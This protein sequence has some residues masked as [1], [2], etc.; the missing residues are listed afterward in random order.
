MYELAQAEQ[1]STEEVF[2][3]GEITV[4]LD[5]SVINNLDS[6][7]VIDYKNN[8]GFILKNDFEVLTF[9]MKFTT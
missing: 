5:P 7:V 9:G 4:L 6:D 1:S 2:K 3:S 8:Y